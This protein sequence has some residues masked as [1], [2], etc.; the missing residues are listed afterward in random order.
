MFKIVSPFHGA[1]LN[2]RHG[3]ASREGLVIPVRGEGPPRE[4]VTV[5]GV[6]ARREGNAFA[7]DI[8]LRGRK[9]EI[10][11]S[12]EGVGGKGRKAC[13]LCGTRTRARVTA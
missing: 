5:N 2:R 6:A 10:V 1:V 11:A 13:A 8:T 4:R 12:S 3:R 7:A 9:T